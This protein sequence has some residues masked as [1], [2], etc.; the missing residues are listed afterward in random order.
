MGIIGAVGDTSYN[1][2][3]LGHLLCVVVG[4]GLA[5]LGPT[6][7]RL[8]RQHGGEGAQMAVD[9]AT[10]KIVFPA[11]LLAGIFGGALVG[12]ADDELDPVISFE[13]LWLSVAGGLWIL[14]LGLSLVAFQ[15]RWFG[16]INPTDQ[17]RR[18]AS[19]LLHLTLLLLFIDMIWKDAIF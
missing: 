15:P 6:L 7:S 5:F 12:F 19:M 10:S 18:R 2:V 16:M 3:L 11:L 14:A 13:E 8:A 9:S 1:L 17:G 4:A